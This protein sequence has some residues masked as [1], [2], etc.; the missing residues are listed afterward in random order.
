M[1]SANPINVIRFRPSIHIEMA[2]GAR[3]APETKVAADRSEQKIGDFHVHVAS[4]GCG[5]DVAWIHATIVTAARCGHVKRVDQVSR[6]GIVVADRKALRPFPVAG[7]L[8]QDEI[9]DIERRRSLEVVNEITSVEIVLVAERVVYTSDF[10][11]FVVNGGQNIVQQTAR[12]CCEGDGYCT[13][14]LKRS[15]GERGLGGL[16]FFER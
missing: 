9:V 4:K 10:L 1:A 12:G 14:H 2:R 16:V 15:P 8:R 5:V 6:D 13:A 11:V 3:T 7:C